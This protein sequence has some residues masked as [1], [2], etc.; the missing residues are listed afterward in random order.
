VGP[1]ELGGT[2]L[3][4]AKLSVVVANAML[5]EALAAAATRCGWEPVSTREEGDVLVTDR[6]PARAGGSPPG[7][8]VVL[9]CEPRPFGAR[10]ALD[11]ISELTAA[12]VVCSDAPSDVTGALE[13]LARGH[14]TVPLRVLELAAQM[15]ALTER[16][17]A[18]LSAVAAGQTNAEIGRGL[19]LSQASVKREVGVLYDALGGANRSRLA[20]I[21]TALGVAPSPARP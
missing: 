16:Q 12:A 6:A 8:R 19:Y 10:R 14:V 21:A 3:A 4:T 2:A 11:S 1:A 9:V 15:P 17:L 20:A 7:N 5:A 13:G 18:V